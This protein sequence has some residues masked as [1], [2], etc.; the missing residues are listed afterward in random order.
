MKNKYILQVYFIDIFDFLHPLLAVVTAYQP[1]YVIS[2]RF[3]WIKIS[4]INKRSSQ[5]LY[6]ENP[7][8][9]HLILFQ[10]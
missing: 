10:D 2:E 4:F 7:L 5:W 6:T 1:L 3:R 8:F 9:I